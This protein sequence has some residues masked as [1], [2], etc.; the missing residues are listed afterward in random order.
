MSKKG[1]KPRAISGF[2]EWLPEE[3]AVELRWFDT[4]RGIFESHGFANIET[5]SV[6][7]LDALLA[8]GETD[9]EIYVIERL[10]SE[11]GDDKSSRLGLHYDVT[12]PFAR[13]A[14]QHFNA[15][16]FPFK[17]YQMQRVWRGERPQEGR[18]REFYQCDLDVI[19]VDHLP[20]SFDADLAEVVLECLEALQ[21]GPVRLH[22]ANRKLLEGYLTGLRVEDYVAA[23][24]ILD[25]LDK[26]GAD[27]VVEQLQSIGLDQQTAE[28]CLALSEIREEGTG[29]ADR[30]RALGV[31]NELLDQ[32]I[33]ELLFVMQHL[34]GHDSVIA[35][36]SIARGF[37]YYTGTVYEGKLL[38][39]PD[40]GSICSGGR[41]EDLAGS[42]IKRKLPGV[43]LSIGLTR[44]FA[45]MRAEGKIEAGRKCP[46][47]VL[48]VLPK[49][50]HRPDLLQLARDMRSRGLNVELYHA[51]QKPKK[52][53]AYAVKK[54]IPH[55][56][57][58]PF[59]EGK[60]HEVKNMETGE[61]VVADPAN[62]VPET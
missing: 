60:P 4:L 42:F 3:R 58:P 45:K 43:G 11:E 29:F 23:T 34:G 24:R 38:E 15:L 20:L 26:I 41:Y 17:R 19:N 31:E 53:I 10:Q 7:E 40:Y 50:D 61:Q 52:Q 39:Y 33:E 13:Y 47:D 62:W 55:V 9:K 30:V 22:I 28:R 56:W 16:D 32:G 14:A 27:G 46:T 1:W 51:P 54:G 12:V 48:I 6:E 2:P 5:P 21:V 59:G 49:E 57:F 25:K 18:Y 35:D 37:D 44:L 36:L 8:K